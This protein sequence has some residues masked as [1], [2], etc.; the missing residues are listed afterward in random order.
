MIC[1]YV[2]QFTP[3]EIA[4]TRADYQAERQ[5]AEDSDVKRVG[6]L[7]EIAFES[8][9]RP[10]CGSGNE[11]T[12]GRCNRELRGPRLRGVR[13][14]GRRQNLLGRSGGPPRETRRDREKRVPRTTGPPYWVGTPRITTL[15]IFGLPFSWLPVCYMLNNKVVT[16]KWVHQPGGT[17]EGV[18]TMYD[19]RCKLFV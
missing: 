8:F 17:C 1:E 12:I 5:G 2:Y 10:G 7:G 9:C 4:R 14:R 19:A 16:R 13:L 6:N 11:A 18:H 3:V 15:F